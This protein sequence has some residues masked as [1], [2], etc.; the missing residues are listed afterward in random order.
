[1]KKRNIL[2]A[3]VLF[4]ILLV[5]GFFGTK[6]YMNKNTS[7]KEN[8]KAEH[9]II[10]G[11]SIKEILKDVNSNDITYINAE[12]SFAF[13]P[14][15]DNL[16]KYADVVIIGNFKSNLNSYSINTNL[17]TN[18]MFNVTKVLKNNTKLKI[19]N[20]ITF[21]RIGGIITLDAYIKN[22]NALREYEFVDISNPTKHYIVQEYGP[23]N[24]LDFLNNTDNYILFL[25]YTDNE[26]RTL[27][28][29]Y[30]IRKIND[31]MVYNYDLKEYEKT[32]LL[33]E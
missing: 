1:M 14:T 5:V 30:G 6:G 24:I 16:Y 26:L 17:Y 23:D 13:K 7:L 25:T 4:V 15:I 33:D 2:L 31:H 11:T 28:S 3:I 12:Y 29:Y 10:S 21:R 27:G 9:E 32:A 8:K 19:T 20:D 22:N 18:T